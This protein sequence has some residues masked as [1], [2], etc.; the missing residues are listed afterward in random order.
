[1]E[2]NNY[3]QAITIVGVVFAVAWVLVTLIKDKYD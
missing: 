2:I 3:P 1:M